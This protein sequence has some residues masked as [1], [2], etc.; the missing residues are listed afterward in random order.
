MFN[1]IALGFIILPLNWHIDIFG[2]PYNSWRIY[3]LIC[4]IPSLIGLITSII[5]PNSPKYLIETGKSEAAWKLLRRMYSM[6]T[7]QPPETFPVSQI[8]LTQTNSYNLLLKFLIKPIPNNNKPKLS[9]RKFERQ[10]C[11]RYELEKGTIVLFLCYGLVK[12]SITGSYTDDFTLDIS[13]QD[14]GYE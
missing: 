14:H 9:S 1:S 7:K 12:L 13:C 4:A 8:I 2:Q 6:N 5:L 11:V 3:L 10:N